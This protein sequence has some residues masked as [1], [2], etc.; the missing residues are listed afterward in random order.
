MAEDCGVNKMNAK[1]ASN[2]Q[3]LQSRF[4]GREAIYLDHCAWRVRVSDIRLHPAFHLSAEVERIPTPGLSAPLFHTSDGR[5]RPPLRWKLRAGYLTAFSDDSWSCGYGGWV[6]YFSPQLIQD[7]MEA[8]AQ[9]G[10]NAVCQETYMQISR[11]FRHRLYGRSE[12]Y[13][14]E[15]VVE[16]GTGAF[17][18]SD[19]LPMTVTVPAS[20]GWV[21]C[22]CCGRRFKLS[23]GLRW[24]GARHSTC[25]QRLFINVG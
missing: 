5:P 17:R 24:D 13:V 25:G 7:V 22:P 16:R 10:E 8:A 18:M 2:C 6:L 3:E 23:D 19:A 14:F 4:E 12:R 21:A 11:L 1:H 15:E 20:S 9:F